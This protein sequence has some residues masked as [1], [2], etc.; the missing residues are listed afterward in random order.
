MVC[1]ASE[2]VED[3]GDAAD[4]EVVGGVGGFED[5]GGGFG[6]VG[7]EEDAVGEEVDVADGEVLPAAL[8]CACR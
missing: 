3:E 4:E 7:S 6:L 2:F 8:G 1:L 5:I